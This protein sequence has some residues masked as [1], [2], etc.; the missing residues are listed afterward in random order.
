MKVHM[1]ARR[2]ERRPDASSLPHP[3][4]GV[5]NYDLTIKR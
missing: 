3:Q 1:K 2:N 4:W 5:W